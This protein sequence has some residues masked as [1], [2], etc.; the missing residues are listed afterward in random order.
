MELNKQLQAV[1]DLQRQIDACVQQYQ[2]SGL[3]IRL[4]NGSDVSDLTRNVEACVFTF[5]QPMRGFSI[6]SQRW[7]AEM[8]GEEWG[9]DVGYKDI[10]ATGEALIIVKEI[11]GDTI[12]RGILH[13]LAIEQGK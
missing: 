9:L 6:V 12:V 7:V 13:H 4:G 5:E 3:K 10:Y 8:F 2:P 11:S 1:A